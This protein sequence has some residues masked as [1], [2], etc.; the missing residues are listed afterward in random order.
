MALPTNLKIGDTVEIMSGCDMKGRVV[1]LQKDV[2]VVEMEDGLEMPV[3]YSDVVPVN[4]NDA[5]L[6][7]MTKGCGK[8]KNTPR[9]SS[10]KPRSARAP[11][12]VDLHL[13]KLPRGTALPKDQ[14]LPYQLSVFEACLR[15]NIRHYGLK[16]IIIHGIGDGVLKNAV[17]NA[18][19]SKYSR[20]C[21]FCDAANYEG[22]AT[23]VC[24]S[25]PHA[26]KS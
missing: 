1:S 20:S 8:S 15:E 19:Q 11:L 3:P 10:G 18:L 23:L 24:I 4:L 5:M 16:I 9:P 14:A 2:V 6:L 26:G 17:R 12:V 25:Y 13:N 7:G 22:S 21:T